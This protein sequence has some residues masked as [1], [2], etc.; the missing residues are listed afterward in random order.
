MGENGYVLNEDVNQDKELAISKIINVKTRKPIIFISI[1]M[2]IVLLI[3]S[4]AIYV[5]RTPKT[6]DKSVIIFIPGIVGSEI[7]TASSF[8]SKDLLGKDMNFDYK[9]DDKLWD[10]ESTD[11]KDSKPIKINIKLLACNEKGNALVTTVAKD[12]D[13]TDSMYGAKNIYGDIMASL[14][15]NTP[16]S[17]DIEFFPYDWRIDNSITANELEKFINKNGYNKVIIVAHSMGGLIA[18]KYIAK[19]DKNKNKIVKLITIGTPFLG[20]PKSLY[21]FEEGKLFDNLIT[22]WATSEAIKSIAPNLSSLYQLLPTSKYFSLNNTYYVKKH[23]EGDGWP[24]G[25][26][27]QETDLK[28]YVETKNILSQREWA[29][30]ATKKPKK[31]FEDSEKFHD[32]LFIKDEHVVKSVDS[33]FIIGYNKETIIRVT[34]KY[35][36]DGGFK[37]LL[38]TKKSKAGDGTVP[39]ISANI[40]YTVSSDKTYYIDESHAQLPTNKYVIELI[41]NIINDKPTQFD[42]TKFIK[43]IPREIE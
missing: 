7:F 5:V 17:I 38:D 36:K 14:K 43:Y 30:T 25:Q 3:M 29:L 31:F 20:T 42:I 37:K 32:S 16:R 35:N 18:S 40:G 22:D 39:I 15:L 10:P 28:N 26:D 41:S 6:P 24:G 19:S 34:E 23:V 4:L 33:Y 9:T 21:I 13:K 1:F 8:N 11:G 2:V 12:P 27:L